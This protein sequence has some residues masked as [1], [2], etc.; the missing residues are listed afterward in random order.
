M[1][2]TSDSR[3]SLV[4]SC[5]EL[6][7][8]SVCYMRLGGGFLQAVN[9]CVSL[10]VLRVPNICALLRLDINKILSNL[11]NVVKENCPSMFM[12]VSVH[13]ATLAAC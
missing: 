3:A 4:L 2:R 12:V 13:Q 8:S 6:S 5:C 9:E 1:Y 11:V 10:A 7:Y